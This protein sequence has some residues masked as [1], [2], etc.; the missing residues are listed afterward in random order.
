VQSIPS[1][2]AR[3]PVA[4]WPPLA[5]M[6]SLAAGRAGSYSRQRGHCLAPLGFALPLCKMRLAL[7]CASTVN[8][9]GTGPQ[10]GTREK[11][12]QGHVSATLLGS[13]QGC[14]WAPCP[15]DATA[16][17]CRKAPCLPGQAMVAAKAVLGLSPSVDCP[18]GP[19][20]DTG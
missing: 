4:V 15:T 9:L 20:T 5:C 3:V 8:A 11:D 16:S 7:P 14:P 1:S 6:G 12:R 13:S 17:G 10:H 18:T 19:R 2:L